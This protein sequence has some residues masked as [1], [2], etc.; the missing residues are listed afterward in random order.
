MTWRENVP[1]SRVDVTSA[2]LRNSTRKREPS[3]HF[4]KTLHHGEDGTTSDSVTEQNRERTSLRKGTSNTEEKTRSD[5]T[6]EGDEL[7]VSRLQASLDI[8]ELFSSADL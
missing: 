5:C 4:T 6:T 7:D 1:K 8:T 2:V 3:G